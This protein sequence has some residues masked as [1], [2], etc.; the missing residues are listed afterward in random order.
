MY[1]EDNIIDYNC[2][3]FSREAEVSSLPNGIP[4]SG[5]TK[6]ENEKHLSSSKQNCQ[7]DSNQQEESEV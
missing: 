6:K 4:A 7:K 3:F 5:G 1:H 2:N